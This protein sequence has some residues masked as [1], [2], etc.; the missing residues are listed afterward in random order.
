VASQFALKRWLWLWEKWKQSIADELVC[1]A[2]SLLIERMREPKQ[3]NARSLRHG[4]K[5]W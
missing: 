4:P 2:Q 1:D 3:L 5:G